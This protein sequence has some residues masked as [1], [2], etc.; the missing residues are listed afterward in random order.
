MSRARLTA[1]LAS[2]RRA[3]AATG[4]ADRGQD[5]TTQGGPVRTQTVERT[6]VE[7]VEQPGPASQLRPRGDLQ[8]RRRRAS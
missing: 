5:T 1:L 8:A 6:R 3:A 7:V 2:A 4:C